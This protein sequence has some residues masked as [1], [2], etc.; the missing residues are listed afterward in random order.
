[1]TLCP[2]LTRGLIPTPK[3]RGKARRD[4]EADQAVVS[5]QYQ[6]ESK[7]PQQPGGHPD[8][9]VRHLHNESHLDKG[10]GAEQVD[11]GLGRDSS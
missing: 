7:G 3:D 1:M 4:T 9:P 2:G 5:P 6:G 11:G 8:P 10:R